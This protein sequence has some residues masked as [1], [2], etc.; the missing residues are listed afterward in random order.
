MPS[1]I[2]IYPEPRLVDFFKPARAMRPW[3]DS[4]VG[5][6]Q[7]GRSAVYWAYRGLGLTPGSRIWLP[8]YHCGVEIDAAIETA[9]SVD[10]YRV[11]AD[12]AV[13]LDD[14]QRKLRAHPGPVL[15]IHY[16][17]FVQPGIERLAEICR[18]TGSI[19]IEDC[20]HALHARLGNSLAGEFAPVSI[21]S[22]YKSL[23]TIEGGALK[24]NAQLYREWTGREFML[25]D[26]PRRM[27]STW[28]LFAKSFARRIVGPRLTGIYR[29]ARYGPESP[30]PEIVDP[31]YD[32]EPCDY[33]NGLG[34][35]A[36]HIAERFDP[37]T[38]AAV[39]RENYRALAARIADK[40]GIHPLFSELP[41][42]ACPMVFPVRVGPRRR[43]RNQLAESGIETYTFGEW[44]HPAIAFERFPEVAT[45]RHEILGLPVHQN[46]TPADIERIAS[47]IKQIA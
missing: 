6:F 44:R 22:L 8:A 34:W 27:L 37:E 23:P 7:W 42:G 38:I 11:G 1:P 13:D 4:C 5:L 41:E 39:R 45:L 10:F 16:Y 19:L 3:L 9:L 43:L 2:T 31:L 17:G 32:P 15:A 26:R 25:P 30:E 36:R 21:Y 12:L 14:I 24:L 40:P 33:T 47:A 18:S 28:R 46:L 20:A 29:R 35:S